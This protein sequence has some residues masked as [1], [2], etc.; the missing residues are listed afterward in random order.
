[1]TIVASFPSRKNIIKFNTVVILNFLLF[2]HQLIHFLDDL[3]WR[4]YLSRPSSNFYTF[5][6]FGMPERS[7]SWT[8][9][10]ESC[11]FYGGKVPGGTPPKTALFCVPW[12]RWT[13]S[14]HRRW[15]GSLMVM[16]NGQVRYLALWCL[17]HLV[18]LPPAVPL[19]IMLFLLYFQLFLLV[20]CLWTQILHL[21][22]CFPS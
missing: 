8:T 4:Q 5:Y 7:I 1:M 16:L 18:R 20:A 13:L 21:V 10:S 22:L 9:T 11:R 14:N 15:F 12:S 17:L 19:H 3:P 6:M 2:L